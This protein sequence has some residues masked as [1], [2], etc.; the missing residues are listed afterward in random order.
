MAISDQFIDEL[1]ARITLS[2][3]VGR[4]V[5]WDRKKS[6]P[7]KRDYW[8]C[9]PFHGE[10][11]P[12]F[13]VDDSKG[14]YHCFGCGVSGDAVKFLIEAEGASFPEAIEQLAELAGLEVPQM[15][16]ATPQEQERQKGL[17]DAMAAAAA[18]FQ[19]QLDMPRG[20]AAASYLV[21]KRQMDQ[22]TIERFGIGYAT[23][24]RQMLRSH[25]KGEGFQDKLLVEAGL[26]IGPDPDDP[27]TQNRE[28]YDRFRD[29][30]MFP[31]R[32]RKGRIVAFGGR[33]LSGK[34][35]AKYLNSPETPIFHKSAMLYNYDRAREGARRNGR[36]LVSEGYMDVIA[37]DRAGMDYAVAPMGT[38]LT[39]DQL[40]LAWRTVA[41]PLM[42]FDGDEAGKRAAYRAVDLALPLLEPGKSLGFI[43]LPDGKDPDD[44]LASGGKRALTSLL[45]QKQ[46]LSDIFWQAAI[47]GQPQQTPEEKAALKQAVEEAIGRIKDSD[48]RQLY[49]AD[50][51]QRL[52]EH[53]G[54]GAIS[55]DD[56]SGRGG[57][58]RRDWQDEA[59]PW[60]PQGLRTQRGRDRRTGRFVV[61]KVGLSQQGRESLLVSLLKGGKGAGQARNLRE[62][63]LI[64][65]LLADPGLVD[66]HMETLAEIALT[67]QGLDKLLAEILETVSQEP[68]LD[69]DALHRHLTL[70]GM[71]ELLDR[72][73]GTPSG[74]VW[75]LE[76]KGH[77]L[78]AILA[79]FEVDAALLDV[80]I[81]EQAL[82]S[83]MTDDSLARL[84]AAKTALER[85]QAKQK[86]I[87]DHSDMDG[88]E[89]LDDVINSLRS[90]K[91]PV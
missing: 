78:D 83:H 68:G 42:C 49:Q 43:M 54:L 27:A 51:G 36:L 17:H 16:R 24:D 66:E 55:L 82:T 15:R 19:A 69:A 58:Q 21:Q 40:R 45:D 77:Q 60:E 18:F 1:R 13:H 12:S 70:Q 4:R 79:Q 10:K 11:S 7:R 74:R 41:E 20:K 31:I 86:R 35:R 76:E 57:G 39:E 56:G 30:I 75:S 34:S 53:L 5:T 44:L 33:D 50:F 64:G 8:A 14:F 87:D 48:V 72:F 25:L 22:P 61:R 47:D 67:D 81:A 2:D 32:D 73:D 90:G 89:T 91:P 62:R 28:P 9:C 3:I 63:R 37:F 38:A 80:H 59:D 6:N 84:T 29:R 46:P 65:V 71:T 26:V 88:G 85:A 52:S 23:D